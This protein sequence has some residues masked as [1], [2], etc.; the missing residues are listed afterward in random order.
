M[1]SLLRSGLLPQTSPNSLKL[2]LCLYCQSDKK[3]ITIV[4]GENHLIEGFLLTRF[5]DE[6]KLAIILLGQIFNGV[7]PCEAVSPRSR[8]C[9]SLGYSDKG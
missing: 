4:S 8:W 6:S 3:V 1:L 7:L 2:V 9:P 5:T